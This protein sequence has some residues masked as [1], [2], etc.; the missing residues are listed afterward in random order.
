MTKLWCAINRAS[1]PFYFQRTLENMPHF[2]G[3][4]KE[5]TSKGRNTV[6]YF[7]GAQFLGKS[8]TTLRANQYG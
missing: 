6:K 7:T 3:A 4:L 2:R 8:L 1:R 5:S